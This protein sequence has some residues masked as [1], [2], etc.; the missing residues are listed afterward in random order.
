MKSPKHVFTGT[1]YIVNK[2]RTKMLLVFHDVLK[3]WTA[4]GGHLEGD[5]LPHECAVR[6]VKEELGLTAAIVDC[7]PFI[8]PKNGG[9]TRM[10]LPFCIFSVPSGH[11]DNKKYF[12][13]RYIMEADENALLTLSE[14]E[15]AKWFTRKQ[16]EALKTFPS[17]KEAVG[18]ILK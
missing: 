9:A 13:F 4:P 12:D 5:E 15:D 16:I 10:P 18:I 14:V 6:E 3:K 1:G 17:I 11:N 7:S 8:K 2:Q